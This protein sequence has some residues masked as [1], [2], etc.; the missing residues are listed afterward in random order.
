MPKYELLSIHVGV[1]VLSPFPDM[2]SICTW[3]GA[4]VTLVPQC[5]IVQSE[6]PGNQL[7]YYGLQGPRDGLNYFLLFLTIEGKGPEAVVGDVLLSTIADSGNTRP[8]THRFF[9]IYFFD[10]WPS[11]GPPILACIVSSP[12]AFLYYYMGPWVWSI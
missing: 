2:F 8:K 9:S 1:C 5:P 12:F 11:F 3:V 10:F 4:S 6:Q 7:P